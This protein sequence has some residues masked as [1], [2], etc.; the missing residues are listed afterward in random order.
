MVCKSDIIPDVPLRLTDYV[1]RAVADRS[2][3]IAGA[4]PG[5]RSPRPVVRCRVVRYDRTRYGVPV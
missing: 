3:F 5:H 1:I 4:A 2:A